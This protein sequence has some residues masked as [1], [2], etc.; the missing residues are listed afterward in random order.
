[1]LHTCPLN[2]GWRLNPAE[3]F[4]CQDHLAAWLADRGNI[5]GKCTYSSPSGR[6][7]C[8]WLPNLPG[9]ENFFF[10]LW[11]TSCNLPCLIIQ[12]H[13]WSLFFRWISSG[14][15]LPH[16][17]DQ[18]S[19]ICDPGAKSSLPSAFVKLYWHKAMLIY[20]CIVCG[21]FHRKRAVL[22]SWDRVRMTHRAKDIYCLALDKKSLGTLNIEHANKGAEEKV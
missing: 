20:L 3:E 13:S 21:C 1:M 17:K 16:H 18:G 7:L 15:G 22:S 4:Y 10:F 8:T 11:R 6:T 19:A 14:N 5:W 12:L 2:P 9:S